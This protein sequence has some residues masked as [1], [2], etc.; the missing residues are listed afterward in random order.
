MT[1]TTADAQVFDGSRSATAVFT[2][3]GE[4]LGS[5]F[6]HGNKARIV[7]VSQLTAS[8]AL[9]PPPPL[10]LSRS[11]PAPY[12]NSRSNSSNCKDASM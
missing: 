8:P 4:P 5:A 1:T 12:P 7:P 2:V 6:L 10:P 11:P 3:S 9:S